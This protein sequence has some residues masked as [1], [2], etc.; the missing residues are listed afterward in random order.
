MLKKIKYWLSS[1]K[2]W[3]KIIAYALLIG[4]LYLLKDFAFIFLLTFLFAYLFYSL[5][6]FI[7]EFLRSKFS[8]D[9][10]ILKYLTSINF[11]VS[12]LYVLFIILVVYF[13]SNLIPLLIKELSNLAQHLPL[14]WEYIQQITEPL[15]QVQHTKEIV[16]S[17][18]DKLMNEKNIEIIV[19]I[20]NHIKHFGGEL[21][22]GVIAFIL[23]YFFVIDRK[24]LHKYLEWI[25]TSSLSF[26]YEEY[27]FL[28]KKIAKWFLLV[29]RAQLKIAIVLMKLNFIFQ[30]KIKIKKE[31]KRYNHT[32]VFL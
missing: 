31:L 26:L 6:K 10:K 25:K 15:K 4:L 18:L 12:V 2:L 1:E 29:F 17:D 19:N 32:K 8:T 5:A 21:M 13:V 14:I 7:S 24:K 9:K 16:S 30:K 23:S 11:I 20:V 3:K 22:K 28:F 27:A